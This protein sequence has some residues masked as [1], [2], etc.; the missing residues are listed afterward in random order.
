MLHGALLTLWAFLQL[1]T[2]I[3]YSFEL[4]VEIST[5][6]VLVGRAE[7]LSLTQL[8]NHW[9]WQGRFMMKF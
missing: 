2:I 9:A 6:T 4:I 1:Q 7:A 3:F 8:I 5:L